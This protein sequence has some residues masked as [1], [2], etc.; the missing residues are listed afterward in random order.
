LSRRHGTTSARG[1]GWRWQRLSAAVLRRDRHV[2]HYC[3]GQA[4][5]ADHIVPK[6][7]GGTD[8]MDNLV[9]ACLSCNGSKGDN[10]Q[11]KPR[12]HPRPRF[13]RQVLT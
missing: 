4:T 7:K 1:Y 13:S 11:P 10:A 3:G 2:C 5:T 12:A 9:A 6:A 8:S